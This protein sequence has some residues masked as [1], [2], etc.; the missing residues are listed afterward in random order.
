MTPG[1]PEGRV[2][3]PPSAPSA[4]RVD[5]GRQARF[6]EGLKGP[7][8]LDNRKLIAHMNEN[9]HLQAQNRSKKGLFKLYATFEEKAR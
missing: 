4:S 6:Q 7:S 1:C 9:R 3:C 8:I 2:G 5:G